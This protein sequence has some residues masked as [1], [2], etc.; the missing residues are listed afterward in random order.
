MNPRLEDYKAWWEDAVAERDV[1]RAR[2]ETLTEALRD[3]SKLCHDFSAP[4]W[5][6]A[7]MRIEDRALAVLVSAEEL[8]AR[9]GVVVPVEKQPR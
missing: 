4:N 6:A 2:V 9:F 3:I 5:Y 1:L 8:S 7:Q